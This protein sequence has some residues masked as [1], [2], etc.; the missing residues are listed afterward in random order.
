MKRE[1]AEWHV[2]SIRSICRRTRNKTLNPLDHPS[3]PFEYY[4]IPAFQQFGSPV[5]ERGE[6]ILSQKILVENGTILFGKLNPP[7][8]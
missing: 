8:S 3:E 4:S 6:Q 2:A 5:I 7:A 1:T